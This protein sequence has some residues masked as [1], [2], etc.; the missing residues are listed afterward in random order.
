MDY[1]L[2]DQSADGGFLHFWDIEGVEEGSLE[3]GV[4]VVSVP[5]GAIASKVS[6]ESA[7]IK[8]LVFIHSKLPRGYEISIHCFFLVQ[9]YLSYPHKVENLYQ[10][11][12]T[13]A[14]RTP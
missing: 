5:A 2:V 6:D 4:R 12:K 14:W 13:P 10:G 8:D 1:D 9:E 7:L 11:Q 3:G